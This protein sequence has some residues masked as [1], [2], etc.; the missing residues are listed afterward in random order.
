MED[1]L[2]RELPPK[3]SVDINDYIV[4]EDYDGTK[5]AKLEDVKTAIASH[6]YFN[7]L[8]DVLEASLNEGD[9]CIALGRYEINDGG[10][11]IYK[12][13]N[14]PALVEDKVLTFYLNT[15]DTLRA[16][17]IHN[18]TINVHQAGAYG[19]GV[20]DDVDAI[21][22][23]LRTRLNVVFGHEETYL[24]SDVISI[25]NDYLHD[26][27]S[28]LLNPVEVFDQIVDFDGSTIYRTT[29]GIGILI[30]TRYKTRYD[31]STSTE[32][33]YTIELNP[34]SITVKNL[35]GV[36][37]ADDCVG[38]D[39]VRIDGDN[40]VLKNINIEIKNPK[41]DL[42]E[43]IGLRVMPSN[44][45]YVDG[46][47]V[48]RIINDNTERYKYNEYVAYLL[49]MN[50]S[51]KDLFTVLEGNVPD[52]NNGKVLKMQTGTGISI[53]TS[54][55]DS[56][57]NIVFNNI[58]LNNLSKGVA[59]QARSP[60]MN[61]FKFSN[62]SINGTELS[63]FQGRMIESI[64]ATGDDEF[65]YNITYRSLTTKQ[66]E[67]MDKRK[68]TKV[69]I[70]KY[71]DYNKFPAESVSCGFYL[72]NFTERNIIDIENLYVSNVADCFYV[73]ENSS[74]I[75]DNTINITNFVY[76]NDTL[77][78]IGGAS[79]NVDYIYDEKGMR[80]SFSVIYNYEAIN[81][82]MI[83][84]YGTHRYG[85][86][87][88]NYEYKLPT[89]YIFG[90]A[91][92]VNNYGIIKTYG[93]DNC[94]TNL[95]VDDKLNGPSV[96]DTL[97]VISESS[98]L[99]KPCVNIS[100]TDSGYL[101]P[102]GGF[103]DL[104]S[105]DPCGDV[106]IHYTSTVNKPIRFIGT[107]LNPI[108][109][110]DLPVATNIESISKTH[111]FTY[112]YSG[113]TVNGTIQFKYQIKK[114]NNIDHIIIT[115]TISGVGSGIALQT[116]LILGFSI[117]QSEE[118]LLDLFSGHIDPDTGSVNDSVDLPIDSNGKNH[119]SCKVYFGKRTVCYEFAFYVFSPY[120][121]YLLNKMILNPFDKQVIKLTASKNIILETYDIEPDNSTLN[122]CEFK[123]Q[124]NI[125]LKG[126]TSKSLDPAIPITLQYNK[127][128]ALWYEI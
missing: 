93:K 21:H 51:G 6:L 94:N 4:M 70:S 10:F 60:Y 14:N 122:K 39:Y 59:I 43:R 82:N 40:I 67:V 117:N 72:D 107:K 113:N 105:L 118:I 99:S 52:Y 25:T 80:D 91:S 32:Y 110:C 61:N 13:V 9:V 85:G 57:N 111:P 89:A 11:G 38:K 78:N 106:N 49:G 46:L 83:N 22:R 84:L 73:K 66:Q 119:I 96:I 103:L 41:N 42:N 2:V 5:I 127:E 36:D 65:P 58:T 12:I 29:N 79:T 28:Q 81:G 53:F 18:G 54:S 115:P 26:D 62:I 120:E 76:Y 100:N 50:F 23:A 87:N 95:F 123:G 71:T 44:N 37:F 68:D 75:N 125:K 24:C 112:T 20:H 121:K 33:E 101:Y 34:G 116:S 16:V 27:V 55:T 97:P 35:G 3:S 114:I 92:K 109:E 128:T 63:E 17:L 77:K 126:S 64:E 19:D 69:F 88:S 90:L 98:S 102:D 45:I 108:F 7:S 56:M 124:G 48:A 86:N 8:D 47:K 74:Y 15:S 1:V 31:N 30:Q 104:S